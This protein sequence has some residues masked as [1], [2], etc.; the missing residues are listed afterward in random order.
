MGKRK[1]TIYWFGFWNIKHKNTG[2]F[3]RRA[4]AFYNPI[5]SFERHRPERDGIPKTNLLFFFANSASGCAR[6]QPALPRG[7]AHNGRLPDGIPR[8]G[9]APVLE[10]YCLRVPPAGLPGGGVFPPR[11]KACPE[12]YPQ[13]SA[14]ARA[15]RPALPA[16]ARWRCCAAGWLWRKSNP[17][18]RRSGCPAPCWRKWKCRCRCCK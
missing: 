6:T 3:L 9:A 5:I 8:D 10:R 17:R 11:K 2:T 7:F 12:M 16:P 15:R 4:G 18:T 1:Q 14:P 13:F